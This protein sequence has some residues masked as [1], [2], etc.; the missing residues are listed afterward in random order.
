MQTSTYSFCSGQD[1]PVNSF[2]CHLA[3]MLMNCHP[4]PR[5]TFP[6]IEKST[7]QSYVAAATAVTA[8]GDG[9]N[10]NRIGKTTSANT[11]PVI[12]CIG[13]DRSTGDSLG[14]LIGYLLEQKHGLGEYCNIYGTLQAPIHALNLQD[15]VKHITSTH[16]GTP[17][18]CVDAS[19]GT[20][21]R[22]GSI[23]LSQRPLRPGLGVNKNLP[24]IGDISITGVIGTVAMSDPCQLQS[25]RL[26]MIMQM[27]SNIAEGISKLFLN[28]KGLPPQKCW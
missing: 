17:V 11:S 14:P 3:S 12:L 18:I 5:G 15:T 2:S 7:H 16:V 28:D 25:I 6:P 19:L 9:Q 26:C 21:D 22:I 8:S 10:T 20:P 1:F 23:T 27:A 24:S 13:T 4:A